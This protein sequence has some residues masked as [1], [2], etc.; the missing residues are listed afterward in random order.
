MYIYVCDKCN[1]QH[2]IE[3]GRCCVAPAGWYELRFGSYPHAAVVLHICAECRPLLGIP[4][5]PS[6]LGVGERLVEILEEIART[7]AERVTANA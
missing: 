1:K 4:P 6:E 5:T 7:E 3:K 2:P